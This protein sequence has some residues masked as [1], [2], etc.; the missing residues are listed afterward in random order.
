MSNGTNE[1]RLQ[2]QER[3][4][5][6]QAAAPATNT[7]VQPG[8]TTTGRAGAQQRAENDTYKEQ[9]KINL[10][11]YKPSVSGSNVLKYPSKPE[12]TSNSDYVI[13]SFFNYAPPFG[14]GKNTPNLALAE[15]TSKTNT[16]GYANYQA[17]NDRSYANPSSLQPIIL[18][19]PED[20]EGE[21]GGNWDAMNLSTVA[22]GALGAFGEAAGED[23][24]QAISDALSAATTTAENFMKKGTGVANLISGVLSK[25][26]F[27]SV[28][29]NDIFSVTT[30]QVLNPNTEVLYKGPKMRT[31][32]LSF[33]M[34]PRNQKEAEQIKYILHALKFATLPRFGGAGDQAASFVRVPQIA[35]VTFMKGNTEHDWVTQFKPSVITNLNI[36]YTPDGAWATLPNGSPVATKL[37]ISF[38]ETKM[39]YAD[40][41]LKDKASY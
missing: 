34:A 20:M 1:R 24:P 40:E 18:Y 32:S 22:R 27:A 9:E 19:M 12:I 2:N 13:F 21:Y 4:R 5:I 23:V 17:S 8:A 37:D 33:K 10:V 11:L 3:T 31:F 28:S 25:T 41:L 36:S 15:S 30:G 6:S 7:D 38:Q 35:D 29:V 26:N 14:G 39:V 16:G